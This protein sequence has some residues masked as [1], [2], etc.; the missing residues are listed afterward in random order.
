MFVGVSV[1]VE[2]G[3]LV[4]VSVGVFVA[5]FVGVFVGVLVGV[6]V[7]V[8]V[9]VFVGVF[10][11]VLV[12]VLVDVCVAVFVGV[13]VAVGVL[14]GV[15]VGVIVGVLVGVFVGVFVGVSTVSEALEVL[16]VPPFVEETV[17]LLFLTPAVEPC[18]FTEN[19]QDPPPVSD[20]PERLTMEDPAVAVIVP[21]P[22]LPVN[23]FGVATTKPA[24]KLSVKEISANVVLELGLSIVKLKVVVL[25][26]GIVAAPNNLL[27]TGAAI[28]VTVFEPELFPSLSSS[29]TLLGSTVAVLARLPAAAGVTENVTLNELFTGMVTPKPPAAQ[30]KA[31]PLIEQLIVPTGAIP[32]FVT[33]NV[34]CG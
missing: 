21:P 14:V 11:G 23:P 13:G 32:P 4:G 34:P 22:Q 12:G 2:V 26:N 25:F 3:V 8:L 16:P 24:G 1:G 19:V 31:V 20:A 33:V 28:T 15:F 27:I 30:L 9:E 6:F 7:G 18:M 10:V 5:V 29:T 17:T